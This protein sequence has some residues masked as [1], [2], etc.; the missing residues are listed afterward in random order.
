MSTTSQSDRSKPTKCEPE[1]EV[2]ASIEGSIIFYMKLDPIRH[3]FLHR[4][5]RELLS[6]FSKLR[7]RW[8]SV[9]VRSNATCED[10]SAASFAGRFE[11]SL[12]VRQDDELLQSVTLQGL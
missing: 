6:A 1:P 9:A 8:G 4:I 11:T 7:S 5:E 10:A 3:S 2:S 12:G